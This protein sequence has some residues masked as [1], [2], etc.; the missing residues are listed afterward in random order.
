MLESHYQRNY[1]NPDYYKDALDSASFTVFDNYQTTRDIF[2]SS[3]DYY[4]L[5]IDSIYYIYEAALDTIN[6]RVSNDQQKKLDQN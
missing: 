4:S 5:N 3:Y 1:Q 2:E 6:I